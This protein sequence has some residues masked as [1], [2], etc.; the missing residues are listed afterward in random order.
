MVLTTSEAVGAPAQAHALNEAGSAQ[1][2]LRKKPP[3]QVLASAHAV[4]RE[5]Q[6]LAALKDTPVPVPKALCLCQDSAVIGTPFY[7]MEHVQVDLA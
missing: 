1:Y 6:V 4:E 2:V 5:Y 7:V 3:G